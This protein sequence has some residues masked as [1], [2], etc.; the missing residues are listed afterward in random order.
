MSKQFIP[1]HGKNVTEAKIINFVSFVVFN[2]IP[3]RRVS[4]TSRKH[5]SMTK[6]QYYQSDFHNLEM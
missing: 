6:C 2:V 1:I 4:L 5:S 3:D